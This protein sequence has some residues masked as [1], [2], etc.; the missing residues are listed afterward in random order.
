V[1]ELTIDE[2]GVSGFNADCLDEMDLGRRDVPR[3]SDINFNSQIQ[4]WEVRA[5]TNERRQLNPKGDMFMFR[6]LS[7]VLYSHKLRK[8]CIQWELNNEALITQIIRSSP[9]L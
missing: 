1:S 8:K 9:E 4:K 5:I 6:K 3:V 2:H 7:P